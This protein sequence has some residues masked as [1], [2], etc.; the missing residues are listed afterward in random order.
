MIATIRSALPLERD[1]PDRMWVCLLSCGHEAYVWGSVGKR[2]NGGVV[3]CKLC[4]G[5]HSETNSAGEIQE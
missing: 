1:G 3:V 5:E 4:E 2:P